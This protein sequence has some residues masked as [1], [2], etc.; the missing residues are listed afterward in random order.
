MLYKLTNIQYRIWCLEKIYKGFPVNIIGGYKILKGKVDISLLEKSI[1]LLIKNNDSFQLRFIQKDE[2]VYQYIEE[3]ENER[4]DFQDFSINNNPREGLN[5]WMKEEIEKCF[6][7][8]GKLYYISLFRLA[9]EEVGFFVKLHHIISDGWSISLMDKQILKNYDYLLHNK[10]FDGELQ[11]SYIDLIEEEKKYLNSK[12]FFKQKEFWKEKLSGISCNSLQENIFDAKGKREYYEITGKEYEILKNILRN[13]S[14]NV[15]LIAIYAIYLYLKKKQTDIIIGMPVFNRGGAKNKKIF[16]MYTNSVILRLRIDYTSNIVELMDK[17]KKELYQCYANKDFDYQLLSDELGKNVLSDLYNVCVNCYNTELINVFEDFEVENYEFYS[18][19]QSYALQ[20]VIKEFT[21]LDKVQLMI[22]Y[23]TELYKSKQIKLFIDDYISIINQA[24]IDSNRPI[25]NYQLESQQRINKLVY[26]FNNTTLN[27]P[28]YMTI[29]ELFEQQVEKT[30]NNIAISTQNKKWTYIELNNLA[31]QIA[32]KLVKDGVRTEEI[33]AILNINSVDTIVC[34]LAILKAGAAYLPI[35]VNY[36]IKRI[37]YILEK[38]KVRRLFVN[39]DLY[40]QLEFCGIVIDCRVLFWDKEVIEEKKE[41]L[42]IHV[43]KHSLVYIIFTSG[44]TGT[45]K[46]VMVEEQGLVNYIIWGKR[47]YEFNEQDIMPFYSSIAFDLTVTSIFMPLLSGGR[48]ALYANEC[49]EPIVQIIH[50]NICT[51]IKLTPAH[52]NIIKDMDLGCSNIRKIIVGGEELKTE[53]AKAIS[54]KYNGNI[55][56]YNEYG[57]TETVVGCMIYKYEQEIDTNTSVPIGVPINN[58]Q[59]YVLDE[60]LEP[61]DVEEVGELYIAG[62]GVARGYFANEALT[63]ERFIENPFLP[64]TRMYKTGDLARYLPC[65]NIDYIGRKDFQVKIRGYRIELGEIESKLSTLEQIKDVV[66]TIETYNGSKQLVAFIVKKDEI[67][68]TEICAYLSKYLPEYMIPICF[69]TV[70]KIPININGKVDKKQL[71]QIKEE[72]TLREEKININCEMNKKSQDILCVFQEVLGVKVISLDDNFFFLGG[73]SIKAIQIVSKLDELGYSVSIRDLL[74]NPIIRDIISN[75][76]E[77]RVKIQESIVYETGRK[78]RS[79]IVSWFLQKRLKNPE[80]YFQTIMLSLYEDYSVEELKEVFFS[81][82]SYH[83][84]MHFNLYQNELFYNKKL[85][86]FDNNVIIYDFEKFSDEEQER[87]ISKSY[88]ELSFDLENEILFK[89]IIIK[90]KS[91]KKKIIFAVH[92]L[93]IDGVS[94]RIVL[95]DF[96]EGLSNIKK[97]LPLQYKR[98]TDSIIK[99]AD[100]FEKQKDV[101]LKTEGEYWK[102]VVQMIGNNR[103]DYEFVND[104]K[105]NAVIVEQQLNKNVTQNLLTKANYPFHTKPNELLICALMLTLRK[106]NDSDYVGIN[107][108]GYGRDVWG[109]TMNLERTIGWFTSIYP[110]AICIKE[111]PLNMQIKKVKEMLRKVPRGG[112]GFSAL[113]YLEKLISYDEE[114]QINFNYLGDIS[115]YANNNIFKLEN[116]SMKL[117]SDSQNYLNFLLDVNAVVINGELKVQMEFSKNIYEKDTVQYL[118]D[119]FLITIEKVVNYCMEMKKVEFTSSDFEMVE[120]SMEEL[121]LL[122]D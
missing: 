25:S 90:Q 32:R 84:S 37:D 26:S 30:P 89:M 38:C 61:M 87:F 64:G 83:D 66:V 20:I 75:I 104:I 76:N 120:L 54:Q 91:N 121:N 113:R 7:M 33:I 107:L 12:R 93:I 119:E 81:L 19:F 72:Y 57:P 50:E 106:F 42:N 27:Y 34:I 43:D 36:P 70:E 52:L 74:L 82:I 15:G 68:E 46:G 24:S 35:D 45:P 118:L 85:G 79:P 56:I 28:Q 77:T 78:M 55:K 101:I 44:S 14:L 109:D 102:N 112:N 6:D 110:I 40:K 62:D 3:Y 17:I 94:W 60:N 22:D 5:K 8:N 48:I 31:N 16:G 23:K 53:L 51:V 63:K 108:E 67:S 111:E 114:K 80:R 69:I 21:D 88:H 1:Q 59:I 95:E 9:E 47:Y 100:C 117:V 122:F 41:N 116:E 29:Y 105:Q 92:H 2:E 49:R 39:N 99:W 71:S 97:G 96:Y 73:D 65:G 18:G 13:H 11:Y 58:T 103:T 4:L 86:Y 115:S 98:K 10:E